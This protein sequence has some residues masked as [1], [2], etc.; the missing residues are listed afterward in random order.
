MNDESSNSN[1]KEENLLTAA[2]MS[3]HRQFKLLFGVLL[4]L[5]AGGCDYLADNDMFGECPS[6]FF[7]LFDWL[8]KSVAK[9]VRE[10]S[11]LIGLNLIHPDVR[12]LQTEK[13]GGKAAD[14]LI[15]HLT[16]AK[17]HAAKRKKIVERYSPVDSK[18]LFMA[19]LGFLQTEVN[20]GLIDELKEYFNKISTEFIHIR[21]WFYAI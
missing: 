16:N 6:D 14:S 12:K 21:G 1:L 8:G 7:E 19:W 2:E 13:A 17:L 3:V 10:H 15:N 11:D 20:N 4:F 5:S 18:Q 9:M